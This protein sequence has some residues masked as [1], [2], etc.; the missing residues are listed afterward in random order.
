M[1]QREKVGD[2]EAEESD[3]GGE[4][5]GTGG[6]GGGVGMTMKELE[7]LFADKGV[8]G[9]RERDSVYVVSQHVFSVA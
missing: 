5:T 4:A 8:S 9:D 2:G 7:L 6:F 1:V 3:D